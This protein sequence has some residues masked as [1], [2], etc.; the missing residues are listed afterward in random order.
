MRHS[1]KSLLIIC[2]FFFF[3]KVS[4]AQKASISG[5]VKDA[6]SGEEL[7]GATVLILG[8]STGSSVDFNG[9]F[10]IANLNPG[11]YNLVI[12]FVSYQSDTLRGLTLVAGQDL[13]INHTLTQQSLQLEGVSVVAT[14]VTNTE[15]A[16]LME[17]KNSKLVMNAVSSEQIEKSQDSD[18]SEVVRRVPGVTIIGNSYVMIRGLSERYNSVM[19]HD[20]F[21][22]SMEADIKSFAFDI[23][24]S[25]LI[26]RMLIYKSPA[27]ELPGEFAGGVVK[28]YTNI[29]QKGGKIFAEGTAQSPII[30]TSEKAPGLRQPGDWGGLVMCGKARNNVPGG[31]AELEG[32]YGAFHGGTDDNDNSGVL[33]YVQI[34]FAGIPINPN[35]EVNS[36]TMGSLG[37][38]T[39]IEYVLCAYGLDDAFEWFGGS[40]DGKYLVAY[41]GLDDDFDV[42]LGHSG[43]I[44][45][46]LGIR[47]ASLADQSG[48]NGFEVDN[49]GA[50]SANTPK[51]SATFSNMTI[52]GPKATRETPI[53][54]QFQH[55]AQ[56]RRNS[57]L[58]I[59]NSFF[60]GY[61]DGLY[62]NQA[63]TAANAEAD[64]LKVRNT[65]LAGVEHWGG[66]G[67]GSAGTVFSGAPA[68]GAQHPNN[69]RGNALKTDVETFD[70]AAWF[71]T[72]SFGNQLMNKWQ[73]AGIS[74]S[75]FELGT[76]NVLPS[77]G[78]PLLSGAN[79]T[80]L[81]NYF[82]QVQFRG[83]FGTSD[84]TQ[85]WVDWNCALTTYN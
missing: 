82:E 18:A 71:N 51:T 66:N 53:S 46:G 85:G 23:L 19:L 65:I 41:R 52:I 9:D 79:F 31:E 37:R 7:I 2:L 83:A 40:V 33:R 27:A 28:I 45:F 16:V 34:N 35:E 15:A 69:P 60:T 30:M 68:N 80:G 62:I 26:D 56:L 54:L 42:D 8:T 13:N 61:P 72:Q 32:G 50:G 25:N 58:K 11:T 84:W 24:P 74:P 78:S 75:I 3:A 38:G 4:F 55:A 63:S 73:D 76:P 6:K 67:Y 22:P 20:V 43:N 5:T 48:S 36:L 81:P 21:A 49:D 10:K 12:S 64:N 44:Q 14:R 70:I 57:E 47:G 77:G 59:H 17:V 1:V 39:V 29:I